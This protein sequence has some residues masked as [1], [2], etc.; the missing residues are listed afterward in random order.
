[1]R[2]FDVNTILRLGYNIPKVYQEF[3]DYWTNEE[4]RHACFEAYQKG[5]QSFVPNIL[6]E[7]A[8]QLTGEETLRILRERLGEKLDLALHPRHIDPDHLPETFPE[9]IQSPVV[10]EPDG[11]WLKHTNVVGINVRTIGSFWN[12]VKYALTISDAQEAIH[13]LP[14]WEA[15][16]VGSIYGISSWQLNQEFYSE[17]LA[18]IQQSLNTVAKQ[19]RAVVNILHAMGKCVGMDVIPHTDRYSQ[20]VL[21]F[22]QHFEWLQRQDTV[23]VDHSENLHEEV[24]K[25]IM[26]FLRQYGPAV[27]D[28]KSPRSREAFFAENF[29]EHRRLRILFGLPGDRKGREMRR[30]MLVKHLYHYGY[31]PVPGTMAPPFRGLRVDT[32]EEAKIVDANGLVW[33]DYVI[34]KPHP[35]SRVFGPLSRYKFYGRINNNL[36]WEIDFERPRHEVWQYV[37]EK[38]ASVQQCYGFDFMRG[39]MSHI[40]MRED[41]V[42]KTAIDGYYDIMGAVKT[43]IRREKNAPYFGYLAETFLPPRDVFGYGEEMDHLEASDADSTL[44]D[45]QSTCV[46]SA[47]FLSRLRRYYDWLDTRTCA[48]SFTVMTGDKDDPR[49]DQYYLKG[50]EVRLFIAFFLT[51]MPSYMGMGFET[52]DVHYEPAPNEYYTKLYVFQENVGPKATLGPYIWGKNGFLYQKIMRLRLYTD[53]IWPLIHG[54]PIRWLLPPDATAEDKILAWTQADETPDFLFIANT[55]TDQPVMRFAVPII[56]AIDP[57]SALEFEFS[58]ANSIPEADRTLTSN[59]KHY[60]VIKMN[61]NEGRIYRIKH[62]TPCGSE[63]PQLVEPE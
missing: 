38:Y 62:D 42:P 52:R 53:S 14:I 9:A 45:L 4:E 18:W 26:E 51:N 48:P 63:R 15:G 22:P 29:P 60:K 6:P 37:C 49:F 32:R 40:Q 61:P 8:V 17:E 12:I 16:V 30:N 2:E 31:E 5:R 46:G 55:H 41:G 36:D 44:G 58:T 54:R 7:H 47:I 56:P 13:I 3:C 21:A 34:T 57:H 19:L 24:Q 1:M 39:D 11:S 20:I 28:E 59:G 10:D 27:P 43:Y 35:M 23:I 25:T 33:R 50:N